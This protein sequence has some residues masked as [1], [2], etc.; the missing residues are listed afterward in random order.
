MAPTL[1]LLLELE[2]AT[3]VVEGSEP[4]GSEL[5][6]SELG[7]SDPELAGSGLDGG[8][9]DEDGMSVVTK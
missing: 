5:G 4:A 8:E 1:E 3:F 9:L 7:G 6:G 2:L